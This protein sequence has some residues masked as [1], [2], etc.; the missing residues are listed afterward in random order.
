MRSSSTRKSWRPRFAPPDPQPSQRQCDHP[1]CPHGAEYRAPQARDRLNDYYWFCL[2]H[3]R[4]YNS[5]WNYY[6]G[7]GPEEIE[8]ETRRDTTWQR[9]TWPLGMQGN[10]RRFTFTV[11]D[12]FDLMDKEAEDRHVKARMPPTPEE[13][14]MKVLELSGSITFDMLK[15]RYKE[16]VKRHHPDANN[17][18]KQAEERFKRIN[19]AYNTLRASMAAG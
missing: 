19:H 9:P 8:A 12:P 5:A 17:G 7:M 10:S 2:D 6:A 3:V 1:G 13:E 16:L 14:A 11:H 18:D 4:E 15:A